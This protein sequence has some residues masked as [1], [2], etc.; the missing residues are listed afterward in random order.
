MTE[1]V[2]DLKPLSDPVLIK[3]SWLRM[4][5]KVTDIDSN[6]FMAENEI[7]GWRCFWCRDDWFRLSGSF[8]CYPKRIPLTLE[9]LCVI[10][11]VFQSS[12]DPD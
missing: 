1:D 3:G 7:Q 6:G 9:V 4:R 2:K 8:L 10:V 11:K 12:P 5:F